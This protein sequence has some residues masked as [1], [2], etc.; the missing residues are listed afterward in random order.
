M[1]VVVVLT[2]VYMGSL[3]QANARRLTNARTALD[4][5]LLSAQTGG[6]TPTSPTPT[7]EQGAIQSTSI[8]LAYPVR[9]Y[10]VADPNVSAQAAI[11]FDTGTKR[12]LFAK[13]IK[14]VH[15][16]ASLTKLMTAIVALRH[17]T[18]TDRIQLTATDVATY[19]YAGDFK[20]GEWFTFGDLLKALL[21]ESSND[22]AAAIANAYGRTAFVGEMNAM[23]ATLGLQNTSYQNPTG[24]DTTDNHSTAA[25]MMNI[26]LYALAHYPQILNIIQNHSTIIY[27]LKTH[28]P[29]YL[30]T[31]NKLLGTLGVIG[32][33]TGYTTEANGTYVAIFVLPNKEKLG[34]V[35]LD[36]PNRFADASTLIKWVAKAY[37]W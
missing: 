37:Q 34:L 15:K 1:V 18:S 4:S 5:A 13:N 33:K 6:L 24:L 16:I 30:Y 17:Y 20:A 35:V 27:A 12:I 8:P 32:G 2:S 21:I 29:H 19:G 25:D 9:N 3:S 7:I 31:T 10:E 26:M 11:V 28:T 23:A 22:A 14:T 36:S